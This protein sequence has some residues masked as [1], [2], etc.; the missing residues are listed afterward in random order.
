MSDCAVFDCAVFARA[1]FDC[2]KSQA[3]KAGATCDCI[4]S[5][6]APDAMNGDASRI[7]QLITQ[8]ASSLRELAEG[9]SIRISA[10]VGK[11]ALDV[12]PVKLTWSAADAENNPT[13]QARVRAIAVASA[14]LRAA[15]MGTAEAGLAA[16]WQLALTLEG[17]PEIVAEASGPWHVEV[18][19]PIALASPN[20][21]GRADSCDSL[22]ATQ[23]LVV[24]S[25]PNTNG[26][27]GQPRT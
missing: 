9:A 24:S 15:Q 19:I 16:A 6:D 17:T 27:S 23:N 3:A 4:R 11:A 20:D 10:T 5:G 7:Q 22:L 12:I 14:N 25:E 26:E 2:A 21:Q 8:F 13:L 1:A 18:T